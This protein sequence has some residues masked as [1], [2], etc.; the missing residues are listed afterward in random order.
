AEDKVVGIITR[1]DLIRV[2]ARSDGDIAIEV[3][4]LLDDEALMIGKYRAHIEGGVVTLSGPTDRDSRR[5]VELLARSVPGVIAVR[6]GK[7]S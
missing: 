6:F 1:R 4:D 2:L 3:E 5:L 7:A